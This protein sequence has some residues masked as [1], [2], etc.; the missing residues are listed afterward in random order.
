M[1]KSIELRAADGHRFGAYVAEPSGAPRGVV[2]IAQEIFGVNKHIRAVTDEYAADGFLA[3]APALFDR[4]EPDYETGYSPDDIQSGRAVMQQIDMDQTLLDMTATVEWAAR[5]GKVAVIGYCWGGTLAWLSAA[6]I[7]GL[8][9]AVAYY[10]GAIHRYREEAPKCPMLMHF[11]EKDQSPSPD[12]A[13]EIIAMHP[14]VSAHF[15]DAGHGFNCDHRPSFDEDA[16]AL[17]RERTLEF[18]ATELA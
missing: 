10:G 6:R 17:A 15:Y 2:V 5:G 8:S 13:R 11:G 12:Q 4:I 14:G 9:A 1:G 3:I 16:S 18:L 7:P